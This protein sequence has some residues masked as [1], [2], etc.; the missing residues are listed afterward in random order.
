MCYTVNFTYSLDLSSSWTNSSI[1]INTIRPKNAPIVNNE[2]LWLDADN[3]TIYQYNG[4]ISNAPVDWLEDAETPQNSLSQFNPKSDSWSASYISPSSIFSSL[5]RVTSSINAYGNGLGFA[6][7]GIQSYSTNTALFPSDDL[8]LNTL[9]PGMVIYD[10]KSSN[11][12]N[13]S[14]T[15]YTNTGFTLAGAAQFV[16]SFGP[17]GL[18]FVF[19][20]QYGEPGNL[21]F[22]QFDY[23]WMYEP[24]S[25]AWASQK[26]TGDIPPVRTWPCVTGELPA[27]NKHLRRSDAI[28]LLCETQVDYELMVHKASKETTEPSRSSCLVEQM[29]DYMVAM[30]A[31][32]WISALYMSFL[33]HHSIGEKLPNQTMAVTSTAAMLAATG[34]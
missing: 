4:G 13:V 10:I 20:G 5:A 11:W 7:G 34:R 29:V 26:V 19:G 30:S 32:P 31:L 2:A 6:L 33:F 18:L 1:T 14:T 23:A 9:V 27:Y 22:A 25:K 28:L 21:Q 17:N 8:T 24:Y 12:Y 16:P 15:D 3:T